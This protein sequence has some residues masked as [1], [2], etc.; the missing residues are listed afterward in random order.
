MFVFSRDS[1]TDSMTDS[2]HSLDHIPIVGSQH[3]APL[4]IPRS[5]D[6]LRT[7]HP[8]PPD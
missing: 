1:G 2:E 7:D 3:G 5:N 6:T 4:K 8:A